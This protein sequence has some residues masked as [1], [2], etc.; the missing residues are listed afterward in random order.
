MYGN[1]NT[2]QAEGGGVIPITRTMPLLTFPVYKYP[3]VD[4]YLSIHLLV[5]LSQVVERPWYVL[6]Y[7]WLPPVALVI[8]VKRFWHYC[9]HVWLSLSV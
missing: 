5:I 3:F 1:V 8:H 7:V 4:E 6:Q 2:A 9:K